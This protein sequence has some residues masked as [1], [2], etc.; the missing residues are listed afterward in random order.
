LK[1]LFAVGA[2]LLALAGLGAGVYGW[3][4]WKLTQFAHAPFGSPDAKAVDVPQGTGPRTL[5]TLLAQNGVVKDSDLLYAY[6]RREKLGPK[7]KAGQYEFKGPLTPI[8]VIDKIASG[9]VKVYWFTVPEGLRVDE[10][11]PILA[12]SELHLDP[13]K[14]RRISEDKAFLSRMKVPA[15][16][17]EGFLFPDTY[18]FSRGYDEE[19]VLSKMVSRTLEEYRKADAQRKKG[20]GLDLLRTITLA[21]IIEKETSAPDERPRISCV[22]H[23]RLR[24]RMRLGA[25]PTV[26][27]AMK[28]LRREFVKNITSK[29]LVTEHPYNTY[30][31]LGLPP[32]PI[33]N[34]G[35]ASIQAALNPIDCTDLYFVSRNDGT[36]VFCP[37]LR[38]H[39][40]AVE[41]WQREYF[42][43]QRN[44]DG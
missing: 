3:Q 43:K 20:N 30:T 17:I 36:H 40:E 34:P 24:L 37:D 12:H 41:R 15:D 35:A 8:Q 7:L 4:N 16:S 14:L 28:L 22:F 13:Q 23:N 44:K 19:A 21:S 2:V 9:L 25:D 38:C 11:L 26:L 29:D 6:L 33:A 18:S 42:R 39:N 10:I 32:G 31:T 27:Y 1:K 5:A